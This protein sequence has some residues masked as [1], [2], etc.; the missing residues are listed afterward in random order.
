VVIETALNGL[1]AAMIELNCETDFVARTDG[2]ITLAKDLA[3][4]ALANA[5]LGVHPGSA[6]DAQPFQGK[7][8][9]E[10]V[11]QVSGTTG[12]AMALKRVAH[13]KLP[14]GTVSSYLHHNGQNGVLVELEGPASE[15]LTALGKDLAMHIAS[16]DP[17]GVSEADIIERERRIAAEQVAQEGKPEAIRGKI[18]EGKI[19]KFLAERTLYGQPFVK[20]DS[21]TAGDLVKEAAK[22]AGAAVAV[23]RFARFKVGEA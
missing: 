2:F 1:D 18:I 16:A 20:D 23:K 17:M 15:T 6:I 12:E 5:P 21:K 8:V 11:K 22:Q 7:T 4:H 3:K 10:L 19:R 9:G 13:Y 14:H